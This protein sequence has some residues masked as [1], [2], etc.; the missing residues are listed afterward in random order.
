M[1]K[2]PISERGGGGG[3]EWEGM[4]IEKKTTLARYEAEIYRPFS[5]IP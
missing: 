4:E 1:L 3:G 2:L 5:K